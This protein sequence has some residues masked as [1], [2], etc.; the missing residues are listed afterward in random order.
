VRIPSV[1]FQPV[2]GC[3]F[4]GNMEEDLIDYIACI[5]KKMS[6]MVEPWNVLAKTP[7]EKIIEGIKFNM[8]QFSIL[9]LQIKNIMKERIENKKEVGEVIIEIKPSNKWEHFLP[10]IVPFKI[11]TL[12]PISN[13]R[14][15][16][17]SADMKNGNIRQNDTI[18]AIKSKIIFYAYMFQQKIQEIVSNQKLLFYT[19]GHI[20]FIDNACCDSEHTE[21]TLMYFINIDS[22]IGNEIKFLNNQTKELNNI[23]N[24]TFNLL[25]TTFCSD[26]NTKNPTVLTN[27]IKFSEAC[28]IRYLMLANKFANITDS[29]EEY[30]AKLDKKLGEMFQFSEEIFLGTMQSSMIQDEAPPSMAQEFDDVVR[31]IRIIK[32]NL[33]NSRNLNNNI[34]LE[35]KKYITEITSF[36]NE[37]KLSKSSK[38]NLSI[39]T[40]LLEDWN[41]TEP[42]FTPSFSATKFVKRAVSNIPA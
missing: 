23:L 19:K 4:K 33:S 11:N 5:A 29:D 3:S 2:P 35:N 27:N 36:I 38:K 13:V 25:K 14:I 28:I 42:T 32:D 22:E 30:K 40:D 17:L 37:S 24:H 41:D 31:D 1:K 7:K 12:S 21:S 34:F 16:Q 8:S 6:T 9:P 18:L 10:A 20:P 15:T 39:L 26:I